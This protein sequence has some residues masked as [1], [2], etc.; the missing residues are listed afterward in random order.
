VANALMI[1]FT[2]LIKGKATILGEVNDKLKNTDLIN[3]TKTDNDQLVKEEEVPEETETDTKT[4]HIKLQ[5][6]LEAIIKTYVTTGFAHI[7]KTRDDVEDKLE[8]I[9]GS[10]K[11]TAK[12]FN[13][14][15]DEI[16]EL[17]DYATEMQEAHKEE[18]RNAPYIEIQ[19]LKKDRDGEF[20]ADMTLNNK[21]RK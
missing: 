12:V 11:K 16:S 6:L 10:E 9:F 2:V 15:L 18:K 13:K 8:E 3:L 19:Q 21:N 14:M 17:E 5:S 20:F 7:E 1:R 4:Y